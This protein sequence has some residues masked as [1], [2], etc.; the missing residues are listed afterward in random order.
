[1]KLHV[2]N[3]FGCTDSLTDTVRTRPMLE[4]FVP[5]VVT[6]NGDHLN[7]GF[8]PVCDGLANYEMYIYNRWGEEVFHT[9]TGELW[10][11]YSEEYLKY[12]E[13]MYIYTLVL[14]DFLGNPQFLRGT[15]ALLR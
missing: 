6:A 3:S 14:K 12:P 9:K 2:E 15:V 1:V 5:N 8:G 11:P 4:C 10:Y 13:G 7:D